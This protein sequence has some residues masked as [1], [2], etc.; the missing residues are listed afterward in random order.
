MSTLNGIPIVNDLV[1][2]NTDEL[3]ATEAVID[4]YSF[5]DFFAYEGFLG[6]KWQTHIFVQTNNLV[7]TPRRSNQYYQNAKNLERWL[8]SI[9]ER[10]EGVFH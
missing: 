10:I 8:N 2:A 1:P 7:W 6:F 9:R 3:K 4:C 5:Y